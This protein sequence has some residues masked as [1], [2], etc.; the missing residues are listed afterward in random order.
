MA[1]SISNI[2]VYA[3][4][5]DAVSFSTGTQSVSAS[6]WLVIDVFNDKLTTGSPAATPSL[7]GGGLSYATETTLAISGVNRRL[8][9]FYAWTGGTTSVDITADFGSETQDTCII[10]VNEVT[11]A[12]SSDP[13]VSGNTKT[14]EGYGTSISGL[15]MDA[16]SDGDNRF[17]MAVYHAANQ[18]TTEEHTELGDFPGAGSCR[19]STS[20]HATT[21][22]T[23]PGASWATSSNWAAITSEVA[24]DAGGGGGGELLDPFG[25]SGFFGA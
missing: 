20:W 17:V 16:Y 7:S 11:G 25:M 2:T 23:T 21:Q 22:D 5:V 15:T 3:D 13:F 8:S 19:V 18:A 10:H 12:D 9:R 24:I 1:I 6:A 14:A 4:G